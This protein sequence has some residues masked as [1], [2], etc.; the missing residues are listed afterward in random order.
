MSLRLYPKPSHMG[1]V[2]RTSNCSDSSSKAVKSR[3]KSL[4]SVKTT[5]P[6]QNQME[7]VRKKGV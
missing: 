3:E 6:K 5:C 1:G 7:K 2:A 4:C